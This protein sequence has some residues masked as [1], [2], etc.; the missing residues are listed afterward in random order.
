MNNKKNDHHQEIAVILEEEII[1]NLHEKGKEYIDH[2]STIK[3][4]YKKLAFSWAAAYL[5]GLA[6]ITIYEE[7]IFQVNKFNLISF[8]TLF[9][10]LEIKLIQFLDIHIGHEQLRNIFKYL[11]IFESKKDSLIKPYTKAEKLLY[12]KNFDPVIIDFSFYL[13][14]NFSVAILGILSL[15]VKMQSEF[16]LS[17]LISIGCILLFLLWQFCTLIYLMY[18]RHKGPS[19][20]KDPR[21]N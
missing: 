2:F 11:L 5:V 7:Q 19:D 3:S 18:H 10:I 16:L 17:M 14:I 13:S 20:S 8:V 4:K 15:A 12:K 21:E 1:G 6:Y 9:V